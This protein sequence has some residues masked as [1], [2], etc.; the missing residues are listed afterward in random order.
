VP[1]EVTGVSIDSGYKHLTLSDGRT[2]VTRA[3]PRPVRSTASTR[4]RASPS[5]VVRFVHE[6]L[7]LT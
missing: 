1:V 7:D 4:L 3:M 5:M 2:I 6:Y